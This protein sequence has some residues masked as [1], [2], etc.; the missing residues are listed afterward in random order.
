[1]PRL[2]PSQDALHDAFLPSSQRVSTRWTPESQSNVVEPERTPLQASSELYPVWSVVDDSKNKSQALGAEATHEFDKAS[3]KAKSKT[4]NIE[5]FSAKYYAACT[6]GGLLACGLTHTIVTPLD[7]VKCRRQVNPKLYTGNFQAWGK[8]GRAEGFRG[9][10]TGWGPTF[11]GYSA[12]GAF[13]Y[14]GYEYFK[15]WYSDLVGAENASKYKTALYLAASAS[16]ELI[17][18]VALC[19]FEAV[20]VRMQTTIPPFAKGTFDGIS[21]VTAK[22]GWGGL[23]KGIYPLWGRQIPYTMMKF[24][25]FENIAGIIYQRLPRPKS[26]YGKGAQTGVSFAAGYLAGILCAIVSHPADVMVSKLNANRL[27][28]EAIGAV[29]GRIYKEIGFMGL[30]NG[31]PVRIVMIGT[32]TGMQFWVY[33]SFKVLLKQ[34][35][36][37]YYYESSLLLC[38]RKIQYVRG[39]KSLDKSTGGYDE[40]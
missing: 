6:V 21:I 7:L 8:I 38:N 13:K 28:G 16:A 4:G 33:D 9:V 24:A 14:G 3:M 23:F 10:Y 26:D 40:V 32:L 34:L 39:T 11:F 18:D 22:E 17:A 29:T 1:M 19:P 5:L 30:W 31:L 15:T 2:F 25:S 20:K 12:Q 35:D 27:P 37:V 36:G